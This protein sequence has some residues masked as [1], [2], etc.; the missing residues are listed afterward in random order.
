MTDPIKLFASILQDF[1]DNPKWDGAVLGKIKTISN[2]KVGS[3]GQRFIEKLCDELSIPYSF[4]TNEKGERLTQMPWDIEIAN[5]KFEL[6][7]A[8][9][10]TSGKFQFDH[11][12]YHRE[13]QGL[14]CLGVSPDNLYF[15]VWSKGEVTTG[16]A[17]KLVTMEKGANASFKLTKA[18]GQLYEI[19]HFQSIIEKFASNFK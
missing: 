2:T 12:R 9:E 15:G 19:T 17:G 16:K 18:P 4:P 10:D 14:L 3:V 5:I 13:Y 11:I 7:T 8:T 6:K 1:H